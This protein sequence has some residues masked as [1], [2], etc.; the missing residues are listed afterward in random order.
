MTMTRCIG[1]FIHELKQDENVF[2]RQDPVKAHFAQ[3]ASLTYGKRVRSLC[4]IT[5]RRPVSSKT[6]IFAHSLLG[7]Q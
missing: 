2:K 1:I 5:E 4:E 6:M 7:K 3:A